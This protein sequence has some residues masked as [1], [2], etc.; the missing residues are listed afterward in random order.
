MI[1][2]TCTKC[3]KIQPE[4]EF[5]WK[6][7]NKKRS[8]HC[9]TC[10]REYVRKH[11]ERNTEY[12]LKKAKRNNKKS[13]DKCIQ[14]IANYLQTHSCLDCGE[15]DILVLEFD[16]KD[17]S[18]KFENVSIILKRKLSFEKLVAEIKKCDI[19]CANCHRKKTAIEN[20]NWKLQFAPVA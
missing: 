15:S 2:I 13:K 8:K 1:N 7:K 18:E 20:N 14:Y 9:K 5:N 11:Y 16:H 10:S 19:R 17:R 12:Y 6:Y 3:K 4:S